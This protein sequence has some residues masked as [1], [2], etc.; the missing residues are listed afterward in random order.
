MSKKQFGSRLMALV[1]VVPIIMAMVGG[2][3]SNQSTAPES[4]SA[5]G[6]ASTDASV[7]ASATESAEGLYKLT[8]Q[9]VL[10]IYGSDTSAAVYKDDSMKENVSGTDPKN[11]TLTDS[12]KQ[13]I[14]AM[15]LKI[16]IEVDHLDEV[17]RRES[18]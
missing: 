16:A 18:H 5:S 12:D 8:Q 17:C 3:G 14:K 4:V 2:C 11:L 13:K 10:D 9:D 1:L 6:A 7:A 15:N